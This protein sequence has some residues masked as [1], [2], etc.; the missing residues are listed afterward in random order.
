MAEANSQDSI[1]FGRSAR[2]Q[3]SIYMR[4]YLPTNYFLCLF[5]WIRSANLFKREL[6][7]IALCCLQKNRMLCRD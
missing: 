4:I 3:K 5:E 6:M 1:I 2:T 7:T